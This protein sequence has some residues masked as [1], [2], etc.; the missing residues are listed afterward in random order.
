MITLTRHLES[1]PW[2]SPDYFAARYPEQWAR[3][4][5]YYMGFVLAHP[6][7]RERPFLDTIV[8]DA[9]EPLASE[10]ER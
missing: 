9:L 5:I 4:A 6:R 7:N 2:I 1:V 10:Q 8:A 3:N